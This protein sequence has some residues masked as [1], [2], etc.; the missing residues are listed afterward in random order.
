MKSKQDEH[1]KIGLGLGI[2]G[3]SARAAKSA[4]RDSLRGCP[5]P[6]LT[7]AFGSIHLDQRAVHRGLT[8][9]LD[10][11]RLLG[12]SCYAEIT[13]AG[14]TKGSVAVLS[15]SFDGAPVSVAQA[16]A[17]GCPRITA[18]ALCRGLGPAAAQGRPLGFFFGSV[19]DGRE[20]VALKRLRSRRGPTPFFGGLTCGDYDLGMGHP[21][22]WTN[23]QY[24]PRLTRSAVRAAQIGLPEDCGIAFGF[25]H[26]W[27][28]VGA[29]FTITRARG[30]K[31]YEAD[32]VPIFDYYRRFLGDEHDEGFFELL[33]QRYAFSLSAE[34]GRSLLKLPVACD[35]K[36]GFISYFP[37]EELQGRRAR[38]ILAGRRGLIAGARTAA[39]RCR[40]ALGERR[41]DLLL[42][43]SCCSRSRILHSR[44][45]D[46]LDAVRGVFGRETP[47][48]G[49]YSGGEIVPFESR[50]D[51]A[52]DRTKPG[53]RFHASTVALLALSSPQPASV[54]RLPRPARRSMRPTEEAAALRR[55]LAQGEETLDRTESF[56]ANISRKSHQDVE[57][58]KRQ[59]EVIHRYTP[60]EVFDEIG[61]RA[62]RGE[63]ELPDA[64][65]RGA[66][67]FMDVKGF[68]A[69]SE[70]HR[71]AEVVAA[72]NA[73]FGPAT[74]AIHACRGD[75]DKYIG[76][77][78]FA[79]FRRPN[80]ALRA[81]KR[82]LSLV[83]ERRAAGHPFDVRIGINAGRAI[84]ANVGSRDR[85]EYTYIGDAVNLAQRLESNCTPGRV[86]VSAGAYRAS[87]VR[88]PSAT[89]RTLSVKNHLRPVAAFECALSRA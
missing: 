18:D 64:E 14:V 66:F 78:I 34:N 81:A 42:M 80:D 16:G 88:F 69:F 26:G 11:S 62:A 68:T 4:A 89:R 58:L 20:N 32:G 72:L 52:A 3:D 29:P 6:D 63:Y 21:D 39:L 23:Y 56:L 5:R 61:A 85:R 36:R 47:V 77:C 45:N 30:E 37:A 51:D 43:I 10:A 67:M 17:C 60:H 53:S 40:A 35:F 33:I 71:P 44:M 24:G 50:Y 75:V 70:G 13:N 57:K 55:A 31:V 9:V 15:L 27:E 74:D 54:G 82:L 59:N 22:F 79:A 87:R 48:F 65:F 46:E 49:F 38:L 41:P 7:L 12:G 28:P 8:S 73:L 19:A 25:E 2:G 84:R 83:A 76:D 86:L 1:V